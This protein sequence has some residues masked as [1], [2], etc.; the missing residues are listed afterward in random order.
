MIRKRLKNYPKHVSCGFSLR[1]IY[2]TSKINYKSIKTLQGFDAMNKKWILFSIILVGLLCISYVSAEDTNS[3][4]TILEKTQDLEVSA[5][6]NESSA[7]NPDAL[8]KSPSGESKDGVYLVIDN[9]ADKE[10]VNVGDTVIWSVSVLNSGF[11]TA[12]NVKVS[13]KLPK[14]MK[15]IKHTQTKG[16]FDLKTGIWDVGD[17]SGN[18]TI[19]YLDIYVK[20]MSPGEKVNKAKVTTDSDNKNNKTYEEEEI[21]VFKSDVQKKVKDISRKQALHSKTIHPT[22]NPLALILISIF[23]VLITSFKRYI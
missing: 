12:K 23:A 21:D 13:V 5:S 19:A 8:G 4:D 6:I 15:Y 11:D 3:S 16:S 9:D 1:N 18:D 7:D 20:A 10:N 17:L 22:G 14:G 2:K